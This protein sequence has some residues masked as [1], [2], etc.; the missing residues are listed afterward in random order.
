MVGG[1]DPCM[2]I[3][4]GAPLLAHTLARMRA[5]VPDVPIRIAAPEFD[6]DNLDAIASGISNCTVGYGFSDK[7]LL[8]IL[9]AAE[10]LQDS[11]V[12]LRLDG[13]HS[14]FQEA[15]IWPLVEKLHASGLDVARSPDNLPPGLTGDVWRAGALRK[16]A[17]RLEELSPDTAAPHYVHPKFLAMKPVAGLRAASIQPP[18]LPDDLLREIRARQTIV[19]RTIISR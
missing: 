7:P 17:G 9:Q 12:V 5:M 10:E 2:R 11:A 8:R 18:A 1:T 3:M 6:R 13:Q 19:F 14:F 16:M 15:V 4:D